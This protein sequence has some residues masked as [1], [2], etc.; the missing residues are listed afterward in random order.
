[1]TKIPDEQEGGVDALIRDVAEYAASCVATRRGTIRFVLRLSDEYAYIRL[2]DLIRPIRFLH[3][4]TGNPPRQFG[5]DGFRPTLVDD[6]NPTRHYI[7]FVFV[8]FWLPYLLG[9]I[10]LWSWEILGFLRYRGTWSHPDIQ[11]GYVGLEHGW[12]VRRS[13]PSAL[14]PLIAKDVREMKNH[15]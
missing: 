10:V 11:M 14:A 7:A 13:G 5:T 4:I 9:V 12:A 6:Q 2:P 8:G 1:M 3:Q 15:T